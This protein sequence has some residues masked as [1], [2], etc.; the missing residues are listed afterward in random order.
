MMFL[1]GWYAGFVLTDSNG[2]ACRCLYSA[3]NLGSSHCYAG[4]LDRCGA[5]GGH[6]VD[7]RAVVCVDG[8]GDGKVRGCWEE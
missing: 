2:R 6:G 1:C 3:Q 7:G 5:G 8:G 4:V